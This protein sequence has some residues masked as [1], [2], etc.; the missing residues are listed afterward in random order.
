MSGKER[1]FFA[2]FGLCAAIMAYVGT[3]IFL[4]LLPVSSVFMHLTI[5]GVIGLGAFMYGENR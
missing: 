2:Y 3:A 1:K 4:A 5:G